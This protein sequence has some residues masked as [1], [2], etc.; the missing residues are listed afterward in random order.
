[1]TQA[2]HHT[3]VARRLDRRVHANT[4]A[5]S[6]MDSPIKSANDE[7]NSRRTISRPD[8]TVCPK[9]LTMQP[10]LAE[11][12]VSDDHQARYHHTL[13]TRRLDRRVHACSGAVS[14]MD[15][16][17]KSANDGIN[18]RPHMTV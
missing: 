4:H 17:I 6:T 7:I 3:L 14:T 16:P 5:P 1:M 11:F 15:S 10:N 18:S 2:H 12:G 13:V 9:E 8:M